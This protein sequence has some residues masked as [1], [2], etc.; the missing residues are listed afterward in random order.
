VDVV[1]RFDFSTAGEILF[2]AGRLREVGPRAASLGGRALVVTGGTPER[3]RRLLGLLAAEGV[4]AVLFSAAGEPT[5][6]RV[7]E[8]VAAANEGDCDLVIGFGGG[9]ALDAAKAIAALVT[10]GGDPL[11]YVEVIG[12]GE[13]L[14]KPSLPCL[15]IPTT[16]GTGAEVTRNAVLASPDHRRKGSLRSPFLLPCAAV[17][18]PELTYSAPPDVTAYTGLDALAQ[19]IE[20][21]VSTRANPLVDGLCREGM[22]R[23]ARSL[24]RAYARGDDRQARADMSLAS[25]L[26]GLALANAGLGAVHGLAGPLGGMLAA[27]HGALCGVLLPH[28]MS[29]NIRALQGS[30]AG[31]AALARYEEAARI[32]TGRPGASALEGAAWAAA[33]ADELGVPRLSR[34]GM[35]ERDIGEAVEMA[36]QASSMK[37][38]PVALGEGQVREILAAAT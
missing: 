31:G 5:L 8:G 16:A 9:S 3:A 22:A 28:V 38:N 17:V 21:F 7:R 27:P 19:L 11:D 18:D 10:N 25:L 4:E 24:R 26:G 35:S 12:R 14:T 15:A 23:V 32:L 36:M 37:A 34:Y 29:A 20:P 1:G 2:G 30:R 13:A 6:D 33:L